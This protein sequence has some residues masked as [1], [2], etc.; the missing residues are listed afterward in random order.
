MQCSSLKGCA[1]APGR[2]LTALHLHSTDLIS[3]VSKTTGMVVRFP[4][5]VVLLC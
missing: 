1:L 5:T 4:L 3:A 2:Q